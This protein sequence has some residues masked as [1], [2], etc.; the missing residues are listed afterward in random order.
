MKLA[1]IITKANYII[2]VPDPVIYNES[3]YEIR[4]YSKSNPCQSYIVDIKDG[5]DT[6]SIDV[7]CIDGDFIQLQ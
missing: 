3:L 7:I 6:K 1:V 5:S 2:I 4:I